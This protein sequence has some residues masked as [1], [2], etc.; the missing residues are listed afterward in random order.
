MDGA[1]HRAN[2]VRGL[3]SWAA[4][5]QRVFV[6]LLGQGDGRVLKS[7]GKQVSHMT[8]QLTLKHV[9]SMD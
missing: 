6:V 4:R 7:R 2:V 3:G 1:S 8:N 9:I 5:N